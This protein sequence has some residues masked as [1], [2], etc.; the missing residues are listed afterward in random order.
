MTAPPGTLRVRGKK[1][2]VSRDS[3][4]RNTGRG[5]VCVGG[6]IPRIPPLTGF[7]VGVG[8]VDRQ[9]GSSLSYLSYR[10]TD[11]EDDAGVSLAGGLL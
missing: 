3:T 7:D 10:A 8:V 5:W 2:A 4:A 6:T 1:D 9:L 11:P